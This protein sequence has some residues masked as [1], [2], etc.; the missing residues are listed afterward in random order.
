M[1]DFSTANALA[2]F[3]NLGYLI[4][5]LIFVVEGPI[6]NFVAAFAASM[7]FFNV[8]I[9]L[10][11]AILGNVV[12]DLIYFFI[13]R[14]GKDSFIHKYIKNSLTEDKVKRIEKYLKHHPG[15]TL[16]VIKLTPGLPVPGLISAGAAGMEF[17]KFLFYSVVISAVQ[18]SFITLLGF[19]S[20]A[21]FTIIY[22]Y[23]KYAD[24]LAAALTIIIVTIWILARVLSQKVSEKIEKI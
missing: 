23:F 14:L 3:E 2:Y 9:I 15:K 19:Y 5:F 4:I 18:C 21:A 11:L 12:G 10:I 8:F 24:Y 6:T 16:V 1:F 17:R 7:G 22:K 13:G 20:G